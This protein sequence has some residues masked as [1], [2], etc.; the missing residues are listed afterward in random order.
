MDKI[1]LS[2]YEVAPLDDVADGLIGC[3]IVFVNVFAVSTSAGWTLIDAGLPFSSG[4]I[5]SWAES[6]FGPGAKPRAIVLTH[7]HFDHTGAIEDLLKT[8]NVPVYAHRLELPYLTGQQKYPP[9]DPGAGGG[10]MSFMSPLYPRGPVD[11][12]DYVRALP[13]D[14]TVPEMPGWICVFTPGHT[15]G[16]V[17]FFRPEDRTLIVGDAF[18]TTDQQSFMAV[19]RQKPELHGPPAYYTPDWAQAKRSV[20]ALAALRPRILAPGHG[21]PMSAGDLPRQ[22]DLL[23]AHFEEIAVPSRKQ[24]S[25]LDIGS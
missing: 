4:R 9:P 23:A 16:H 7:G 1:P 21:L 5:R 2:E 18:C 19:A 11:I 8:W 3:R 17:S 24:H 15:A 20:E 13:D 22:L 6:R 14:G 10:L 25:T 12:S